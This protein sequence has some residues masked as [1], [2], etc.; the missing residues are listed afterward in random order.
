MEMYKMKKVITIALIIMITLTISA[1]KNVSQTEH[2]ILVKRIDAMQDEI[3]DIRKLL[4]GQDNGDYLPQSN[5]PQAGSPT[6]NASENTLYEDI[7]NIFFKSSM[8]SVEL[9]ALLKIFFPFSLSSDF[10]NEER[11]SLAELEHELKQALQNRY[12]EHGSFSTTYEITSSTRMSTSMMDDL[13]NALE[14]FSDKFNILNYGASI[15]D[16]LLITL[17]LTIE[18]EVKVEAITIEIPVCLT[19]GSWWI[20]YYFYFQVNPPPQQSRQ[21]IPPIG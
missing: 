20:P 19:N 5:N 10:F 3:N 13:E 12:E 11:D 17:I 14:V 4:E 21:I 6:Q 1:C 18:G 15:D 8:D 9:D 7:L 16:G 2:D